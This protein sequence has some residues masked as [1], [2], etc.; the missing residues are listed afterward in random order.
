MIEKIEWPDL[1]W[2]YVGMHGAQRQKAFRE[3]LDANASALRGPNGENFRRFLV[4]EIIRD[5]HGGVGVQEVEDV[6]REYLQSKPKAISGRLSFEECKKMV[7]ENGFDVNAPATDTASFFAKAV[8]L[9]R[10]EEELLTV[11]RK[12]FHLMSLG[13]QK[14]MVKAAFEDPAEST[15]MI[16]NLVHE[17]PPEA[18]EEILGTKR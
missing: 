12:G 4:R 1:F 17:L 3:L 9:S 14:E 18:R 11:L 16:R 15:G 10:N 5:G 2:M 7:E 8:L 13:E 6:V